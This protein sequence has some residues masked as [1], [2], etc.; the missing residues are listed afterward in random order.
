MRAL[1][2]VSCALCA[3]SAIIASSVASSFTLGA[4]GAALAFVAFYHAVKHQ[5]TQPKEPRK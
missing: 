4:L 2:S 3:A 5:F 1:L